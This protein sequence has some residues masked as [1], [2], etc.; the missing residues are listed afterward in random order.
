[1]RHAPIALASLLLLLA[2]P[3][4]LASDE[5][6]ACPP[7]ALRVL[8]HDLVVRIVPSERAIRVEDRILIE[9]GEGA[10]TDLVLDESLALG[11]ATWQ[12]GSPARLERAGGRLKGL[13]P[14]TGRS[15][16]TLAYGGQVN[17]DVK[18][19]DALAWVAGDGT[20]GLVNEKGV[21]LAGSSR[22]VA[23]P[24]GRQALA[25][26]HV[27]AYIPAPY[28]V[29]TQGGVPE[30]EVLVA[31][32]AAGAG[33]GVEPKAAPASGA[34][35]TT[36][37]NVLR[38]RAALVS[39]D[40]T[41]VAGPY[42]SK[43]RV[44]DGI[45]LSTYFYEQDAD[46][47][48]LWLDAAAE[49]VTRYA[50]ILGRYP[51]PKF[52]VVANFFSTGY[53]MPSF[54]LLGDEVIRSA[55]MR[56]KAAGGRIPA[57]YLDHEYVHGWF[58]NG[59]FVDYSTGN[60]CEGLTTYC[61]NYLAKELD[62]ADA[63]RAHRRGTLEK[64]SLRVKGAK[65]VP[66]RAFLQKVEDTDNDIGY[67]KASM[68]FHL[69]RRQMG[70]AAFWGAVKSFTQARVGTI[71]SWDAWLAAFDE[72][73]G[74][75]VSAHVQP[76]LE[77][78]GL[79][80]VVIAGVEKKPVQ[81][82]IEARVR[83]QQRVPAGAG[84]WPLF[85]PV[86][87]AGAPEDKQE[88]EVDLSSGEAT[89]TVTLPAAPSAVQVDPDYHALRRIAEADLPPCLER[90]LLGEGGVVVLAGGG[91]AAFRPLAEQVAQARGWRVVGPE[92]DVAGFAGPALVLRVAPEGARRFEAGG[93]TYDDP[94]AALLV[95]TIEGGRARTTFTA[96]SDAAA[97]RAGRLPFYAWDPWVV[98]Q[99]GRP[100][101]RDERKAEK[102]STEAAFSVRFDELAPDDPAARVKAD[103][104]RLTSKE[105]E[106]RLPGSKGHDLATE[107][108]KE[109]V[110]AWS[111]Q[112]AWLWTTG[113]G[114]WK[115]ESGRE[116]TLVYEDDRKETIKDAFR[117]FVPGE[118]RQIV[119]PE[120]YEVVDWSD[121]SILAL[122]LDANKRT[123]SL[124]FYVLTPEAETGLAPFLDSVTDVTPATQA[125]LAKPGRDGK[126][127]RKP[128]HLGP[129]LL[130]RRARLAPHLTGIP[131]AIVAVNPEVGAKLRQAY[132]GDARAA[133]DVRWNA[134]LTLTNVAG[135]PG[136]LAPERDMMDPRPKPPVVV[137]C[138][139]YDS[140]GVQDGTLFEGADDNA[141]G[142]AC[143]LEVLAN[144]P[145]EGA[146]GKDGAPGVLVLFTDGEE[147]G[148]RGAR[149]AARVLSARYDVRAVINVDSIGRA[150]SKPTHVVGLSTHPALAAKVRA[151]LEGAGIAI[152][153]DIDEFAYAHGSDHM[154]FHDLE[155][156]AITLWASDYAVM[157]SADDKLAKVEVA[158]VVKI[159]HALA[160]LLREDLAGVAA[161]G[162]K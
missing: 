17:D 135:S 130:G 131:R 50:P 88:H 148:L 31:E 95:S 35:A 134:S 1:M 4:P 13:K 83:L 25:R 100:V 144:L 154:P 123:S 28:L 116:I 75:S 126:P 110:K 58:G 94:S 37:W 99:G 66:V 32:G 26:H 115:R 108:L 38:A 67:G 80:E 40:L 19:S 89:L 51:H 14:P 150:A 20:R 106:G 149:H 72:A 121:P 21:Y 103:L 68:V 56:A 7:G 45:T 49:I 74:T 52:D 143:L 136:A 159:A 129:W 42:V 85:V 27:K 158:G 92:L 162:S 93:K 127:R 113:M 104:E 111:G 117:P 139:H 41:L 39:D 64:W 63:A 78:A 141:S 77:R 105:L 57:G 46:L 102:P 54:T 151:A 160:K 55:T 156:P 8:E 119:R 146:K 44:V 101:A 3:S 53:G 36:T 153:K 118:E 2:P 16:L 128:P 34:G 30:R 81:G 114:R 60:W 86:R 9:A 22:W 48:D 155:V 124:V 69:A 98:F 24:V 59:L 161:A 76:Y 23:S 107:M 122:A 10:E 33:A 71:V 96:L 157:D 145:A 12:D 120:Y 61:S 5:A 82:G 6:P 29:V 84:P 18:K 133:I 90:T 70:D 91:E 142:V 147:W 79:P 140:H 15:T 112:D 62:G 138:A 73:A 87:L 43:S 65:D 47:Q 137:L 11:S 125:E 109:R 152:G 97:Q 132:D